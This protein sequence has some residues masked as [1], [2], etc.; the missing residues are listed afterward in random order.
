[1]CIPFAVR[2]WIFAFFVGGV[3]LPCSGA[4]EFAI[5]YSKPPEVSG[6]GVEL[7]LERPSYEVGEPVKAKV[8]FTYTGSQAM[9]VGYHRAMFSKR[10]RGIS[11]IARDQYGKQVDDLLAGDGDASTRALLITMADLTPA[12]PCELELVINDWATFKKPGKYFLSVSTYSCVDVA[13]RWESFKAHGRHMNVSASQSVTVEIKPLVAEHRQKLL[14]QA[15]VDL[16]SLNAQTR[17]KAILGLRYLRDPRSVPWLIQHLEDSDYE[18][19]CAAYVAL[20]I[21]P[22]LKP[23]AQSLV[24]R[25]EKDGSK[26]PVSSRVYYGMLLTAAYWKNGATTSTHREIGSTQEQWVD[27]VKA[28]TGW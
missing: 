27:Y 3:G 12:K 24:N 1:M 5:M 21:M 22:D 16:S 2:F 4:N 28:K 15:A 11:I 25:L 10:I 19:Q 9:K 13:D 23:V 17:A 8:R 20:A 26:L 7:V 14:Q 6:L 18:N